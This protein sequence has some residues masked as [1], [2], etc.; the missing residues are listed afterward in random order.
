MTLIL[1]PDL[2]M[3]MMY[4]HTKNEVSTSTYSKVNSLNRWTYTQTDRHYENITSTT[5]ARGN[6]V[7]YIF[8]Y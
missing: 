8:L 5:Y 1:N 3:V 7:K 4:H 6:Y 2:D